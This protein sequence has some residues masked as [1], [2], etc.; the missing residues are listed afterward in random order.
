MIYVKIQALFVYHNVMLKSPYIKGA[1]DVNYPARLINS[2]I[3]KG[4]RCQP[5][6]RLT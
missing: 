6:W 1:L 4:A 3:V 5:G 2:P